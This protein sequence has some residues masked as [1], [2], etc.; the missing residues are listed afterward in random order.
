[1]KACWHKTPEKRPVA[2]KVLE[3]LENI[4]EIEL[5]KFPRGSD[6]FEACQ[7]GDIEY[8]RY[9]IK[10]A[11][12]SKSKYEFINQKNKEGFTALHLAILRKRLDIVQLLLRHEADIDLQ[13]AQEYQSIHLAAK[14]GA[15]QIAKEL[16]KKKPALLNRS[17][18]HIGTPLHLAVDNGHVAMIILLLK[19]GANINAPT[20]LDK[21]GLPRRTPLYLA[22]LQG[23]REIVQLLKSQG[24]S[25][26]VL[27]IE[28]ETILHA[29]TFYEHTLLLQ[30]LLNDPNAKEMIHR[31]DDDGKLPLHNAV[32][33]NPKPEMVKLLLDQGANP[34][35]TN[36][37]GYTP[38]HWAAKHGHLISAKMLFEKELI[39][40]LSISMAI[41]L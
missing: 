41:R 29:A 33:K 11:P 24:A 2:K 36:K 21:Q 3:V 12:P 28:G 10:T 8:V 17:I 27:S 38:L 32:W 13:N 22:V 14:I 1:M 16:L 4:S 39:Q 7:T 34:N 26:Q 5:S 37:F 30:D 6:I 35:A 23:H 25:T 19:E 15:T 20:S 40:L 31:G 9:L 18:T